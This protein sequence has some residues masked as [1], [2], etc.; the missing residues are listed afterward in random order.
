MIGQGS[1]LTFLVEDADGGAP[2]EC[3]LP[4]TVSGDEATLVPGSACVQE[5]AGS[6]CVAGAVTPVGLRTFLGGS[7]GI[8]GGV[9]TLRLTDVFVSAT[10]WGR[11]CDSVPAGDDQINLESMT[12]T[13]QLSAGGG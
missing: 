7:A 4:F 1:Q 5:A 10:P 11:D 12:A 3:A 9:M 13:L 8:S 6:T 2:S